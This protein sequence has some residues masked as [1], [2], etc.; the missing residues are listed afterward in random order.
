MNTP[1]TIL[2][3]FHFPSWLKSDHAGFRAFVALIGVIFI[4]IQ[5]FGNMPA[6]AIRQ[7]LQPARNA[8]DEL[9]LY[10]R[11]WGMFAATNTSTSVVRGEF[12]F[13][14]GTTKY[15]QYVS[16]TPGFALSAWNEVM[17]DL[18][19]DDNNDVQGRYL[20]GFLRYSC[21]EYDTDPKNP[22]LSVAFQQQ[23]SRFP[24]DKSKAVNNPY[25]TRQTRQCQTS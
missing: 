9:G 17:Q 2:K 7:S 21:Q 20:T 5:G 16:L 19:F 11:G 12:V 10:E 8:L 1:I 4:I 14:D 23:V 15:I 3:R 24:L 18:Q 13:A 6:S 22:L 25:S